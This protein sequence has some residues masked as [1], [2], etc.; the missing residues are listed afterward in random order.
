MNTFEFL[1]RTPAGLLRFAAAA[2]VAGHLRG[3]GLAVRP[4][5]TGYLLGAVA[6]DLTAVRKVFRAKGRDEANPVHVACSSLAMA[7]R[8]ADLDE[9]ATDLLGRF[10]PGPLTVVVPARGLP[11][12]LVTLNGTVGIRVPDHPAT[13]Q[14]VDLL[15]VPITATSLNRSGEESRPLDHGTLE[16]LDWPPGEPVLVL[17][18]DEA[19]TEP[20]ASTLVRVTT[21]QLEL[22]RKGPVDPST[23]MNTR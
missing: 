3:G 12:D 15:G 10:T 8:H 22:L 19:I 23:I 5:E 18:H 11:D 4:T 17:E 20:S 14:V 2:R 1:H 6:T 7:A 21:H 16:T 13:L 9:L